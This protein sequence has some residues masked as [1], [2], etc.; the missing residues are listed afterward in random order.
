MTK[1]EFEKL[2][3]IHTTLG[4]IHSVH[5]SRMTAD[6]EALFGDA[7]EELFDLLE[8][9]S[10]NQEGSD[11]EWPSSLEEKWRSLE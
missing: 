9:F 8:G 3:R 4:L 6:E 11:S 2:T 7:L 1:Q 10:R 5:G